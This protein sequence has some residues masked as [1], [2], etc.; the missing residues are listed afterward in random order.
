MPLSALATDGA[1]RGL[2]PCDGFGRGGSLWFPTI[3]R[4]TA[5][6]SLV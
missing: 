1:R 2:F 5:H 4:I 6:L 3:R